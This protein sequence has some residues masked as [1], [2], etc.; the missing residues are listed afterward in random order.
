M[1]QILLLYTYQAIDYQFSLHL[2][3]ILMDSLEFFFLNCTILNNSD[4]YL[5]TTDIQNTNFPNSKILKFAVEQIIFIIEIPIHRQT[6][7]LIRHQM[8]KINNYKVYMYNSR[9]ALRIDYQK[10]IYYK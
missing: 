3:F 5:H 2:L 4:K 7:D 8:L 6:K 9:S 10:R 1:K